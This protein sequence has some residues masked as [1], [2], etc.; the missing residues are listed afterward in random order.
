MPYHLEKVSF[1]KV[2]LAVPRKYVNTFLEELWDEFNRSIGKVACFHNYFDTDDPEIYEYNV[3]WASDEVPFTAEL[4]FYNH[5]AKGLLYALVAAVDRDTKQHDP[6]SEEKIINAFNSTLAKPFDRPQK[7]TYYAQIPLEGKY[8]LSGDYKFPKANILFNAG[9]NTNGIIG[10][11]IF[12]VYSKNMEE[13]RYESSHRA[14]GIAAAL[15]TLT[16]QYFSVV[17][18]AEWQR[19]EPDRFQEYWD[20]KVTTGE[21]VN[22]S[23]MLKNNDSSRKTIDLNAPSNEIIEAGDCVVNERV[24]LPSM[25]DELFS[26]ICSNENF[27]QSCSRFSEGLGMRRSTGRSMHKIHM[28]SYELIAYVAAIEALLETSPEKVNVNCPSCGELMSKE[29]RKISEKFRALVKD[30]IGSN[31]ILEKAFKDLY[32][33]RSKFVHTGIDLHNFYA[34]R[35]NRPMI[36]LGKR[37]LSEFPN[38]YFNIHEYTGYLLRLYF[39]RQIQNVMT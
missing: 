6:S 3:C 1:K 18:D 19:M 15:T 32:D 12:P 26:I 34:H 31:R 25:A 11:V 14:I 10:Y 20:N 36:L 27:E 7:P 30:C 17:D 22:D 8:K 21:F 5:T 38:Y 35:S 23:R 37:N 13:I 24:C 29:E 4:S 39:Y 9:E 16:Q 33:D 2:D 28:L